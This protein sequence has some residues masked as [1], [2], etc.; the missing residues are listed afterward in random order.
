MAEE[1]EVFI[2]RQMFIF[3]ILDTVLPLSIR[4]KI[5][6]VLVGEGMEYFNHAAGELRAQAKQKTN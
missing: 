5:V 3:K 6:H 4:D 2:E 1:R